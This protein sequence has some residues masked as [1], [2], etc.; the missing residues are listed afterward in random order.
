LS[1][2]RLFA[3]IRQALASAA[4][5]SAFL[6]FSASFAAGPPPVAP[7][8]FDYYVMTLS[9]SPGFCDLGGEDR[10]P[11]QC[12]AGAGDGFVVHGLWPND[13][14]GADPEDCGSGRL[15][16]PELAAARDLYPSPGLARHEY[17]T[18]GSCTGLGARDYFAAVRYV[19]DQIAI[20]PMLKA[21]G[22]RQRLS[23]RAI[24]QAFIDV[25]ANLKPTNIAVT[26][27]RGELVDVRICLTHDLRAFANCPRV[28]ARGCRSGSISVSP[29]R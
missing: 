10:S 21:P 20:P 9:W 19:R 24:E 22:E 29:V 18:H 13:R 28:T 16:S 26:C 6:G 7:A 15:S 17:L 3:L 1:G 4:G 11:Q 8:P 5:V 12:A 27:V 14:S 23:P 2:A 25:N